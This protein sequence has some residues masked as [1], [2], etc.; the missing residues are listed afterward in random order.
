MTEI[1]ALSATGILGSGFRESSFRRALSR[2]PH[3][4]GCDAGSTDFGPHYLGTD[5]HHFSDETVGRD[6]RL[7]MRAVSAAHI[8]AIIGSAGTA[9]TD[10]QV[11]HLMAMAGA[12]AREEGLRFA[13]GRIYSQQTK[14]SVIA[15]LHAGRLIPLEPVIDISEESIS[16][17]E[18][19]VGVAGIEPIQ[20]ALACGADLVIAGRASDAALFAAVPVAHGADPGLAWH[21]GKI[22]ECGAAC[23]KQRSYPD[24]LFLTLYDD[25]F[26]VETPNPEFACS[27]VS[28]A[29]HNLYEAASAYQVCEPS[30]TL[31]T[32]DARYEAESNRA[33][34]VSGAR[35]TPGE[36]YSV[37]LEGAELVGYS[38]IVLGT[39]RDPY[40]LRQL[41]T[42]LSELRDA[43]VER[44]AAGLGPGVR[45]RYQL[46][47]RRYGLD[48]A[49]GDAEP[50]RTLGHE[51]GLEIEVLAD[52]P[53]LATNLARTAAHVALHYPI[54]EWD[55]LISTLAFPHSPP[56]LNRG[57]VHR[58]NL[59]HV[60]RPARHEEM[61][62]VDLLEIG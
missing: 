22:L 36:A 8:P 48:A 33:V 26:V 28:V 31:D 10:A 13:V 50:V 5:S 49:M 51:I 61:F 23:V 44:F 45:D 19:I 56:E 4:I 55:G 24:S 20:T 43:V 3:F 47:F 40:L 16:Q 42:W 41:D 29:S 57:A 25:S 34:R 21:A 11:D 7:I 37:K 62:K 12:I 39:L 46:H 1:R 35:F 53:A 60:V 27:P 6:L 52:D 17:S 32:Q 18:N 15:H 30:G 59:N 54:R 58:F 2:N 9:G 14:E 38:S